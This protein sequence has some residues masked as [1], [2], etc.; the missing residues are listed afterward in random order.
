MIDTK[1][2]HMHDY[3]NIV[4]DMLD[5]DDYYVSDVIMNCYTCKKV[6]SYNKISPKL[7]PG[8]LKAFMN[9]CYYGYSSHRLT[10]NDIPL[11]IA[12]A[13]FNMFQIGASRS[14]SLELIECSD[15]SENESIHNMFAE[16]QTPQTPQTPQLQPQY[17]NI[18]FNGYTGSLPPCAC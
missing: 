12:Q 18:N 14:Y 1:R 6:Q 3:N 8:V 16:T 9:L 15:S 11:S 4:A 7:N 13:I 5:Q 2:V 10:E 17:Y